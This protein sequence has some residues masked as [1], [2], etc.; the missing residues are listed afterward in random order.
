MRYRKKYRDAISHCDIVCYIAWDIALCDTALAAARGPKSVLGCSTLFWYFPKIHAKRGT[1]QN[2]SISS[3]Q[4]PQVSIVNCTA[5]ICARRR[6]SCVV[7]RDWIPRLGPKVWKCPR[8]NFK[9]CRPRLERRDLSAEVSLNF[10]SIEAAL[11]LCLDSCGE[12]STPCATKSPLKSL[13]CLIFVVM[14]RPEAVGFTRRAL[15]SWCS[16]S[17]SRP[18]TWLA[19]Y[20]NSHFQSG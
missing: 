14:D 7:S 5:S 20:H 10:A 13:G 3:P 2:W 6:A 15:S 19:F 9:K 12:I 4:Q 17:K 18:E 11:R 8:Q 1:Y 16:A